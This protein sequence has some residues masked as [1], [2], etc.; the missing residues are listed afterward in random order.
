MPTVIPANP[1][2]FSEWTA[3]DGTLWSLPIIAWE[4]AS[5]GTVTAILPDGYPD[6]SAVVVYVP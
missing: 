1:G 4:I 2:F 5:D 6:D 3:P